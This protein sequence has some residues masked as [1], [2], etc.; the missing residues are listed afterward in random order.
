MVRGA[1]THLLRVEDLVLMGVEH[2]VV[3]AGAAVHEAVPV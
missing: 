3:V 1:Q 2:D